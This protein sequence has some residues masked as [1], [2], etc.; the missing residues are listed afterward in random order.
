MLLTAQQQKVVD[1]TSQRIVVLSCAGSGKTTVIT[2]RIASLWKKGVKPQE[3]L[4]LTFSNKAAQEMKKRICKENPTLGAKVNVK[5]FHAFGLEIVKRFDAA[6]GFSGP[7]SIAKSSEIKSIMSAILKRRH[8]YGIAGS[9]LEH[10]IK[11]CKSCE[12]F[13]H[14][15]QYDTIFHEYQSEMKQHNLVDMEDMIWLPVQLLSSE[16]EVRDVISSQYKYIFVD[17]YQD[18]NEAQNRL[19]DLIMTQENNVCLVGDDDQAIYD[20][21]GAKPE[22]IRKKAESGEYELIKLETNFRSQ[23]GIIRIANDIIRKNH[24]RVPKEIKAARKLTFQPIFKRLFSQEAEAKYV[25]EKIKELIDKEKYNPSDIAVLFP[26]NEQA[27]PIKTELNRLGVECDQCELDENA[28]Y[29][30]F[31]SVLQSITRLNSVIEIGNAINFPNNCFDNFQFMDAK[32]AYCD[33]F[34]QECNYSD[35][36]WIDKL[37]LSD[38][39]FENCDE[40]R[41]RY[42][43]ITQLNQAKNW[44]PTQIVALY[45]SFMQS[46][47]YDTAFPEQYRFVLQV[48]D[49]AQNYEEAFGKI[50]LEQFLQHLRLSIGMGDVAKS[51]NYNAVNVL[52]MHR[53]KGLEF[54][55]VFIIGVQVGMLPNDYFIHTEED[56]EAQR[57]LFYVAI[58][59]AK[60]LLF[61]TSFKD[62]FGGS[63]KFSLVT[64]GFMAEIPK[65]SFSDG[66][67]FEQVL[68]GLPQRE[69]TERVRPICEIVEETITNTIEE[70]SP[71]PQ[72]QAAEFVPAESEPIKPIEDNASKQFKDIREEQLNDSRFSEL[73][74]A[75]SREIE[76]PGKNFVVVVGAIDIKQNVF[77]G[78]MKSNG[79]S[80]QQFELFDYD[81]KGFKLSKYFNNPRCI[82]II[83]GPEAHRIEGVDSASLKGKILSTEG[84]SYMVDLIDQHI[85]KSSL[86]KAIVKIKWNFERTIR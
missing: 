57:R 77:Q 61:L 29:G 25:A 42:S 78:I 84:Y 43:L 37:Y 1:S 83:L 64:H 40:F 36:Q 70:I 20:W 50:N 58:T 30:R 46:K 49:I 52:T 75:L 48:F 66:Q 53:A 63:T 3:I 7:V 76:I 23:D 74:L 26:T 11:Q 24:Q 68:T 73:V 14:I 67:N 54:K 4:A 33:K 21:R 47:H 69:E 41:E 79:F 59:R 65:V 85:T 44:K 86:Q 45:I 35:L 27:E 71:E 9:D 55:V 22:Y 5:T 12:E 51:S 82:G 6:L 18:T 10:Y 15:E 72:V 80:K 8:A 62:P 17:E 56:L 28:Q 81:G 60:D 13:Y 32:A 31:I 34:G 19:L 2:L 16:K 38:L 39:D